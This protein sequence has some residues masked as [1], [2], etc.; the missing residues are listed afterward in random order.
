V[1]SVAAEKLPTS[2]KQ[3]RAVLP[4]NLVLRCMVYPNK[5]NEYT[6]ECIDLDMMARGGTPEEAFC[7]LKGA[8]HGYLHVA[9]QGDPKGLVPRPSPLSH[10][11]KYHWF[12]LQAAFGLGFS[13][14]SRKFLLCDWAPGPLYC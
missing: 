1:S 13:G 8:I 9:Y 6:A 7:S 4:K 5:P 12:A 3:A 11:A 14:A 10:R 2:V